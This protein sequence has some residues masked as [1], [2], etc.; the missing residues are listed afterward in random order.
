MFKIEKIL[1]NK[2]EKKVRVYK[3]FSLII[4]FSEFF[5]YTIACKNWKKVCTK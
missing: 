4:W 1:W 5:L 3:I 2:L